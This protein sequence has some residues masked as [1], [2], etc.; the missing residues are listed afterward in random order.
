MNRAKD[1]A[2]GL[3]G[4]IFL[5]LNEVP[6]HTV[7]V[8][9]TLDQKIFDDVIHSLGSLLLGAARQCAENNCW[10]WFHT[11]S[12]KLI[13]LSREFF[14]CTNQE[15]FAATIRADAANYAPQLLLSRVREGA[16]KSRATTYSTESPVA[17]GLNRRRVVTDRRNLD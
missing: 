1:A 16:Y 2:E 7:E 17:G 6:V 12:L 13:G 9:I 8:F 14:N 15:I 5:Q 3:F 11:A 10:P 4:G